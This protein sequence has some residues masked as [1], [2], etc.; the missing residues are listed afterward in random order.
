MY[1]GTMNLKRWK[2]QLSNYIDKEYSSSFDEIVIN[3]SKQ[4]EEQY[5]LRAAEQ[6]MKNFEEYIVQRPNGSPIH[7]MLEEVDCDAL[8]MTHL[9]PTQKI[10]E[11]FL[12]QGCKKI[13]QDIP[14]K[15]KISDAGE[16]IFYQ[17]TP[18]L[19]HLYRNA[20]LSIPDKKAEIIIDNDDDWGDI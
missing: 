18:Y 12:K 10:L 8:R 4:I 19:Q 16:Y 13:S 11:Y 6:W 5:I 7:K 3:F 15:F 14:A 2:T 9:T 20:P 17:P 1:L